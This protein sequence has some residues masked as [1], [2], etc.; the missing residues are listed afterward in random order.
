MWSTWERL[1]SIDGTRIW[2]PPFLQP[3]WSVAAQRSCVDWSLPQRWRAPPLPGRDQLWS[4]TQLFLICILQKNHWFAWRASYWPFFRI[5][6]NVFRST[7]KLSRFS[8]RPF[9]SFL[10]W[11]GTDNLAACFASGDSEIHGHPQVCHAEQ[12]GHWTLSKMTDKNSDCVFVR[13]KLFSWHSSLIVKS[14]QNI[15]ELV[16]I[17][18]RDHAWR[19][20]GDGRRWTLPGRPCRMWDTACPARKTSSDPPKSS[21]RSKVVWRVPDSTMKRVVW[22]GRQ[23]R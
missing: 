3:Q 11:H 19:S 14:H 23:G 15:F 7:H 2:P 5:D 20:W 9:K 8:L 13:N 10:C 21:P 18:D 22:K 12:N 17:P 1:E 16:T 6:T 4:L